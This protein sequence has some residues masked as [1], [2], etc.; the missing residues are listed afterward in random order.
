MVHS[1][2]LIAPGAFAPL[3]DS[4]LYL[5]AGEKRSVHTGQQLQLAGIHL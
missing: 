2:I 3:G 5:A 4:T 1:N